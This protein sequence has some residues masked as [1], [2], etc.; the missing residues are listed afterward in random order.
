MGTKDVANTGEGVSDWRVAQTLIAIGGHLAIA[1]DFS[2]TPM[3][4]CILIIVGS[5][6]L[7]MGGLRSDAGFLVVFSGPRLSGT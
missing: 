3:N 7:C 5:I 1:Q 6:L 4:L 2:I